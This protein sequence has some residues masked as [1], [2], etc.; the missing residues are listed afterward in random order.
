MTRS[1]QV[2][3]TT[4]TCVLFPSRNQQKSHGPNSGHGRRGS[5]NSWSC[6]GFNPAAHF[7]ATDAGF[8]RFLLAAHVTSRLAVTRIG[9]ADRLAPPAE[10]GE[11]EARVFRQ[12]VATVADNHFLPE[13]LPLL[14]SY[15]RAV[16]LE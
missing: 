1:W 12:T 9:L 10:L 8:A 13:D 11:A 2:C 4:S 7:S 16:V 5:K 3:G 15:A 6:A 14:C